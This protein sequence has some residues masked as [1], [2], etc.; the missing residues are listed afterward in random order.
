MVVRF[1]TFT[2]P[3]PALHHAEGCAGVSPEAFQLPAAIRHH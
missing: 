3:W 2:H 1:S